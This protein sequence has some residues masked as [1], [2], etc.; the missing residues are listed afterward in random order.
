MHSLGIP[1]GRI[2]WMTAT[3]PRDESLHRWDMRV[4]AVGASEP[5]RLTYGSQIG[6]RDCDQRVC[7]PAQDVDC[8]LEVAS[9]HPVLGGWADDTCRV[10]EDTPSELLL[11][12]SGPLGGA[13]GD[14]LLGFAIEAAE[15]NGSPGGDRHG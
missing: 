6:G 14:V 8:R 11:G 9:R 10:R 5:A 12:F 4:V 15:R 3:S 2:I 7:I 13:E 1:A